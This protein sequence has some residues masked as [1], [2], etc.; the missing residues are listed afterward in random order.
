[1]CNLYSAV[2]NQQAIQRLFRVDRD[3]SGNLPPFPAIFPD[4]MAPVLRADEDGAREFGLLRW[5]MPG[6]PQYGTRPVTN[7]RNPAS[8]HWRRWLRPENR[9]LVPFTAFC[10]YAD[11][12]PRK[13]PVWFARDAGRTPAA[14]A[15]L[16]CRWSGTRGTK[17]DPVEGEHLLFGFLTTEPNAEVGA[18]HPKA[19]PVVLSSAED[20]ETWMTAP[21]PV[22]AALQRPLPDGALTVVA[23]GA[24][25]DPPEGVV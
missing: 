5:G 13:T 8:P 2:T 3:L 6:P 22:A 4:Q 20:C 9:C 23:R 19:M 24:R 7:I 25:Q 12:V 17:A 21:W 18:V 15:G 11:T 16:W 1:M 10:E 14:F